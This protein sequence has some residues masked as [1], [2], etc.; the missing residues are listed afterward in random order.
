MKLLFLTTFSVDL[1]H[2]HYFT[3][4]VW[5][6]LAAHMVDCCLGTVMI[7]REVTKSEII[8]AESCGHP[9]YMLRLPLSMRSN[10]EA[11]VSE[12]ASF[13]RLIAPDVIHSNMAEGYDAKA[14]S[15]CGIPIAITI[16]IGGIICPRNG[17]DGFLTYKGTICHQSVSWKCLHCCCQNLPLSH[18]SYAILK[19]IP[20]K[21]MLTAYEKSKGRKP[22]FYFTAMLVYVH[23]IAARMRLTETYKNAIL[24]AA[25]HRLADILRLNGLG[26][27]TRVVPHGVINYP[28][29][30]FTFNCGN[31]PV[32]FFFLGRVQYSKGLHVIFR[33]LRGIDPNKYEFHILGAALSPDFKGKLYVKRLKRMARSL[34]V[35]FHGYINH[36]HLADYIKNYHVMVHSTICLE[37]YGLTIAESLAVGRPVLSTRCGGAEMQV[38]D[39]LNGW[40]VAPNDVKAMHDKICDLI[41]NPEKI[42]AAA[43]YCRLPHPM[44]SYVSRLKSLYEELTA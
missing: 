8:R 19:A 27:N 21:F 39:G 23:S 35:T 34:N 12:M 36:D 33:A 24:I 14:A 5:K 15:A 42:E 11:L 25:N 7:V 13:F 17:G 9:Y 16:H 37:V 20:P 18:L 32:K 40:L 2:E 30:P 41:E 44:N 38:K 28:R 43:E 22:V 1:E 26:K 29:F 6:A 10:E 4:N 31:E 3:I